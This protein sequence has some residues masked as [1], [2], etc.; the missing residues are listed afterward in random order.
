[1]ENSPRDGN[2]RP[3]YLPPENLYAGQE[4]AVKTGHET[5]D[6]FQTGNDV[7][8]G[9]TMSPSLFKFL[10]STSCEMQGWMK[11]KLESK[12]TGEISNNVTYRNDTT[13]MSESEKLKILM[14]K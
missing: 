2:I 8:Q 10:Q 7:C 12:L 1:M 11:H 5:T 3:P 9:S 13:L 6:W 4:A 14:I